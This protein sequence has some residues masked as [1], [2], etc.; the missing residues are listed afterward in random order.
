MLD[1]AAIGQ[2]WVNMA[3]SIEEVL[4]K[5]AEEKPEVEK[6]EAE[7]AEKPESEQ[8]QPEAIQEQP[9]EKPE[10]EAKPDKNANREVGG[11]KAAHS[12]EKSKRQAIERERDELRQELD[13]R[14]QAW[15]QEMAQLV[16]Q[17]APKQPE[18]PQPGIFDDPDA[19]VSRQNQQYDQRLR[20][21]D[22][23]WSERIAKR[24]YGDEAFTEAEQSLQS[25]HR[26]N[27]RDP[28]FFAIGQSDDPAEVM[29]Q[30]H[31]NQTKLKSLND[32]EA[33]VESMLAN[34]SPEF[35]TK[36][37]TMLGGQTQARPAIPAPSQIPSNLAGARSVGATRGKTFA[38]PT[39]IGEALKKR[40]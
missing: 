15:R 40:R 2:S 10:A 24:H 28:V 23:K 5:D 35:K 38:G 7:V 33:T 39:P 18:Q 31:Q 34:A 1:A 36:L 11:L 22:V 25:L 26:Q 6:P 37:L 20:Q 4:N 32:P 30:W 17:F 19:W 14:E 29:M 13:R 21:Q 9:E 12:A 16:G 8:E 3:K 27:P